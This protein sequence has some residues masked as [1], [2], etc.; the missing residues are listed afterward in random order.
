[1]AKS[2]LSAGAIIHHLLTSDQTV[3]S[4]AT[5]VFPVVTDSAQLPYVAYR[6]GGFKQNSVKAGLP[7]ADVV[8]IEVHCF[9]ATYSESVELAEAVRAA[10]D[11][12]SAELDGLYMRSCFLNESEE[13]YADD[14]FVQN[15]TF[16]VKI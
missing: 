10:L 12:K 6:R 7:G 14:A 13:Y 2:S 8:Q 5:M 11:N 1:M 3:R 16:E 15:L 4:L 9:A